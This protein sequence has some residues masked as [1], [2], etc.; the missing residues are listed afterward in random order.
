MQRDLINDKTASLV[1]RNI[2]HPRLYSHDDVYVYIRVII[3]SF[4]HE[5][6]ASTCSFVAIRVNLNVKKKKEKNYTKLPDRVNRNRR[7]NV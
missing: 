4:A 3:D 5:C 2:Y 7:T 6:T 1:I